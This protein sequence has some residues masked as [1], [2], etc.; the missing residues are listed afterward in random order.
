MGLHI[1]KEMRR[2]RGKTS[3]RWSPMCWCRVWMQE[4]ACVCLHVYLLVLPGQAGRYTWVCVY[5]CV[6]GHM[7][8][9]TI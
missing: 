8:V 4:F 5:V 7:L 6:E 1:D 3:I 2:G 9:C